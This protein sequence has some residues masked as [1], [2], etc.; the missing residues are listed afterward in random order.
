MT[1]QV[2]LSGILPN[3]HSLADLQGINGSTSLTQATNSTSVNDPDGG[4]DSQRISGAGQLFS[5]LQ[6]LQQQ[7]PT[8]FKQVLTQIASELQTAAQQQGQGNQAQF[9]TQL[10]NKFQTAAQTGDLTPLQPQQGVQGAHHG[11]HHR[12][13]Q[14]YGQNQQNP[15]QLLV[16]SLQ[17][18]SQQ[19][20]S[21][22]QT[23]SNTD[24]HKLFSDIVSQVSAA[25]GS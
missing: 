20:A 9:L 19:S 7:D 8:K 16:N 1:T 3:S 12:A 25:L 14:A 18:A 17:S 5:K 15:Q 21:G 13:Q 23:A 4:S 6:Q 22:Q 11:H 24:L 10:A 2:G